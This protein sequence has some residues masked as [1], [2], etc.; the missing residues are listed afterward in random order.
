MSSLPIN[1]GTRGTRT[2]VISVWADG[3]SAASVVLPLHVN[4]IDFPHFGI[5][6]HPGLLTSDLDKVVEDD[7][8][9]CLSWD[10][11]QICDIMLFSMVCYLS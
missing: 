4:L 11:S 10:S 1:R 2:K 3:R 8:P 9:E 5:P 6:Y 7:S